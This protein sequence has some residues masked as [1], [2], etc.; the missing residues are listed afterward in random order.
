M[1]FPT[2][3]SSLATDRISTKFIL[4]VKKFLKH[5]LIALVRKQK[6][7]LFGQ[8][9]NVLHSKFHHKTVKE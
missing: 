5:N 2:G 8:L 6:K 7:R 9:L 1:K 3:P 4:S